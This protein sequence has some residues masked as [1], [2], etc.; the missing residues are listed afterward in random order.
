[1]TIEFYLRNGLLPILEGEREE[2]AA[3]ILRRDL[4]GYSREEGRMSVESYFDEQFLAKGGIVSTGA[5]IRINEVIINRDKL[6]WME[7][8]PKKIKGSGTPKTFEEKLNECL[9]NQKVDWFAKTI[10]HDKTHFSQFFKNVDP[11][12]LKKRVMPV[13]K[14]ALGLRNSFG[15][16]EELSFTPTEQALLRIELSK[17]YFKPFLPNE[18]DPRQEDESR[19]RWERMVDWTRKEHLSFRNQEH[20]ASFQHADPNW[21]KGFGGKKLPDVP[22]IK[23]LKRDIK[24]VRA[25]EEFSSPKANR[26]VQLGEHERELEEFGSD[27]NKTFLMK[28]GR[29][30]E[31]HERRLSNSPPRHG[32]SKF[33]FEDYNLERDFTEEGAGFQKFLEKMSEIDRDQKKV[34]H[35]SQRKT[36]NKPFENL[37]RDDS[38]EREEHYR[39][40]VGDKTPLK[41]GSFLKRGL[42]KVEEKK[43]ERG[44]EMEERIDKMKK[45]QIKQV[46]EKARDIKLMKRLSR[47]IWHDLLGDCVEEKDCEARVADEIGRGEEIWKLVIYS[48]LA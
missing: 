34:L 21:K 13:L 30:N 3:F 28:R 1:M 6:R 32:F 15:D 29:G 35:K 11:L 18:S 40:E 8:E 5:P 16:Q 27:Q 2:E 9:L 44:E 38:D 47:N 14:H 23:D 22:E 36:D 31:R 42:K 24:Y 43:E 46:E 20:L 10:L 33:K 19:K 39:E 45:S 12:D 7:E 37:Q 25:G 4:K 26:S 17:H 48:N 41:S